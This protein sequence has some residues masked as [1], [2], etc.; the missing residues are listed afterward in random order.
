MKEVT[1]G[2]ETRSEIAAA[3]NAAPSWP[4]LPG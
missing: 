1:F 2:I 4:G 3:Q